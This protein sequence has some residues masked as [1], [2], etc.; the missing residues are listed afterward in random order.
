MYFLRLITI[1]LSFHIFLGT[2][3]YSQNNDFQLLIDELAEAGHRDIIIVQNNDSLKVFYWPVGFRDEYQGF[4]DIKKSVL[5]FL[6]SK[7]DNKA[8][9]IELI[10]TSWGIQT[11]TAQIHQQNQSYLTNFTRKYHTVKKSENSSIINPS[12]RLMILFDIPFIANFGQP[13]DPLIFKTGIRPEIRYRLFNGILAYCQV[14]FYVHNE[15]SPDEF[16]KPGNVGIMIAKTFIDN[17]ISVTNI[18]AFRTDIYGL[19]EEINVSFFD[20]K[21]SLALRGGL[22]GDLF[23]EDNKFRYSDKITHK[24]ILLKGI[25]SIDIYDSKIEV[26][27]GRFLYGDNGIGIRVARTFKEIEIGF[28]G[29][30]TKE[31]IAANVFFSIPFFPETRKSLAKYGIA[32]AKHFK[33]RYWYYDNDFGRDTNISTSLRGIQGLASPNHFKYMFQKFGEK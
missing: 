18:G 5:K 19:D 27:G 20:D 23:F 13:G 33:F 9:Y 14:D 16:Y 10:Q 22:F 15:Y 11:V 25:Y 6:Q 31:D 26:M 8:K 4:I 28:T 29:I 24:L 7:P 30:K 32:P 2:K 12:K 3:S 21:I 1:F 17:I